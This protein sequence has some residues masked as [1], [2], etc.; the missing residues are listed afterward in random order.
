[1]NSLYTPLTKKKAEE[2]RAGEE[3][4]LTGVIYTARDKA[5]KRI[6]NA[7]LRHRNPSFPLQ[8]QIIYYCGPTPA[9]RN[10][11]IGSCGPT[12][13]S[14]MDEFT[15]LLLK[16]GLRGMIGKGK[17]TEKVIEAIKRFKAVYFVT[18]GG[19]GAL[20]STF[21]KKKE[22]VAYPELKTEA[23]YRLYVEDFPLIVAIDS[24]GREIF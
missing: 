19:C 20:L 6:A 11:V 16:K 23:V 8:D 21:V 7:L 9:P 22:V 3:I 15:P 2:L 10:R 24:R 12:T 1:M 4:S 14:R 13:S 18:F 17:R 5:H